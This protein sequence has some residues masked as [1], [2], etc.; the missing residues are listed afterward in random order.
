MLLFEVHHSDED[1]LRAATVLA[2]ARI[3]SACATDEAR[4]LAYVKVAQA[5]LKAE[6]DVSADAYAKRAAPFVFKEGVSWVVQVQYKAIVAQ[7]LD[8]KKQFLQAALRYADL[9][10]LPPQQMQ[11]QDLLAMLE[12]AARCAILSPAGPPRQRVMAA[13]C[14]DERVLEGLID[15]RTGNLLER[16]FTERFVAPADAQSFEATLDAHQRAVTA[17]GSTIFQKAL[18]EHNMAAAQRVYA[19]IALPALARRLG[20]LPARAEAIAAKMVNEGRLRAVIDQVGAEGGVL[21]FGG[22]SEAAPGEDGEGGAGAGAA[23]GEDGVDALLKFDAKIKDLCVAINAA[24][25]GVAKAFPAV[26]PE[27]LR[28][29]EAFA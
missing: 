18:L 10:R 7:V 17:D 12:K 13:L 29:K 2:Q 14:R 15:P 6:D 23:R 9:S 27:E 19:A 3:E 20:I 11:E 28:P 24:A 8:A 22:G 5:F 25:D 26:V 4:A 1:F 21:V 16:M